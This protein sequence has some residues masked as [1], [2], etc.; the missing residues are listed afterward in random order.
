MAQNMSRADLVEK[1][2]EQTS[3]PKKDVKTVVDG[4]IGAITEQ[5]NSGGKVSLTGF[6]TFEVRERQAREGVQAG[7][8]RQDPD[9][10]QQVSCLQTRE[11]AQRPGQVRSVLTRRPAQGPSGCY[12]LLCPQGVPRP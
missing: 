9:P 4:F 1:V 6:G 7:D 8:H 12:G 3:M 2:A 10:R 5:L 11:G